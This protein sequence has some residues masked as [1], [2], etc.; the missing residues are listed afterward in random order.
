MAIMPLKQDKCL[1]QVEL[2]GM[3]TSRI[4]CRMFCNIKE[5]IMSAVR[6]DRRCKKIKRQMIIIIC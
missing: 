2:L 5:S 1:S 4:P 6:E 3:I